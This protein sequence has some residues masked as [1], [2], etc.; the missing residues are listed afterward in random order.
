MALPFFVGWRSP[1]RLSLITTYPILD[2]RRITR[3]LHR[4]LFLHGPDRPL[5]LLFSAAKPL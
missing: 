1:L 4:V 3:T 5:L 2:T